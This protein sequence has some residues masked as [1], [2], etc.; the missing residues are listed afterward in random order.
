MLLATA[1]FD[2]FTYIFF[3]EMN[4]FGIKC[5]LIVVLIAM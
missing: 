2:P 4:Y 5:N 3:N 1:L